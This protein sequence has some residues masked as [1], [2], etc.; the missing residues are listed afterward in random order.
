MPPLPSADLELLTAYLD[1]DL[2]GPGLTAF[3]RRL[4]TE[5]A[6]ADSLIRLS[7]DEAVTAEWATNNHAFADDTVTPA[8]DATPA[9][10]WPRVAAGT[11]AALLLAVGAWALFTKPD[12]IPDL[13]DEPAYA[14]VEGFEG[15]TYIVSESGEENPARAGQ[16]LKPGQQ[17]RTGEG[18]SA[19]VLLPLFG[20]VE[21]GTD[22][23]VRLLPPQSEARV[24][25]EKGTVYADSADKAGPGPMAFTTPHAMI[26]A[27]GSTVITSGMG[28][29]SA[30]EMDT[31]SAKVTSTG[32]G[33][34]V[35]VA[36][37][38]FAVAKPMGQKREPVKAAP[39]RTVTPRETW[40]YPDAP[41][42]AGSMMPGGTVFAFATQ[43]GRLIL[44]DLRT[45]LDTADLKDGK[46]GTPAL[47]VSAD[48]S[49]L[50]TASADRTVKVRDPHTGREVLAF[51]KQKQ[52]IRA[53]AVSP[54]GQTVATA[55]GAAQGG[56]EIKIWD[57][58]TGAERTALK[59]H[60]GIIEGLTFSPDGKWLASASRDGG[61]RVWDTANWQSPGE[62]TSHVQGAL[63]VAFT[64]DAKTLI[65]GGRDGFV[66]L[67][68]T[69]TREVTAELDPPP[70]EITCLGVSPD[71]RLLAAGVGGTVWI[72]NLT[73]RQ[74][75]QTLAGHKNKVTSVA[76]SADGKTLYSAGWDRTVKVWDVTR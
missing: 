51:K 2:S 58:K 60:T 37:G 73:S 44:R 28:N 43:D 45:G 12:L 30:V 7:R 49:T 33:N 75:I 74:P 13:D 6:L 24:H 21:L 18:G 29:S 39:P 16:A 67:W 50:V 52:E 26:R 8:R 40:T 9:R 70:K 5:P 68:D 61:T 55:G 25:V 34:T 72:W 42:L 35:D 41:I 54:D 32:D 69:R 66:R 48:G 47:A 62:A 46:T 20:R 3:Q 10:R 36:A 64:P 22:T 53:V 65:T 17:L 1:D 4:K 11:A 59:G 71:G 14:R 19:T 56:A 76:F 23:T 31:G 15:D 38:K 63:C 57:A 27:T